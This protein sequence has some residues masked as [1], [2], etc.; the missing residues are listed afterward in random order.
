MLTGLW[1]LIDIPNTVGGEFHPAPE[2][3]FSLELIIA[4]PSC[5][6]ISV[7]LLI[8]VCWCS[9]MCGDLKVVKLC[10]KR[11]MKFSLR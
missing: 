1:E 10:L 9:I 2:D 4:L 6:S 11:T 3:N 5:L 8:F 7:L